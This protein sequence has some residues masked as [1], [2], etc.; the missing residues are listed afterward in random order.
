VVTVARS[1]TVCCISP[2]NAESVLLEGK[3][4]YK[5]IIPDLFT[6]GENVLITLLI[7]KDDK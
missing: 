1:I 5:S 2:L 3:S 6:L 7:G 4:Y